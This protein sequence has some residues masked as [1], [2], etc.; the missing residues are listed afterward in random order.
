MLHDVPISGGTPVRSRHVGLI[1]L[2]ATGAAAMGIFVAPSAAAECEYA[3]VTTVCSQGDVRS[4]GGTG[5]TQST[6]W[7]PYP[8]EDDWY[9]GDGAND[10]L[11]GPP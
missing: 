10:I 9:C 8:C 11:Y 2:L 6:V 7:F 4:S 5:P 1:P 3:S